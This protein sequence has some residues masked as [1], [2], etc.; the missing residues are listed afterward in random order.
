MTNKLETSLVIKANVDGVS[1]VNELAKSVDKVNQEL[2]GTKSPSASAKTAI[3]GL[4]K[5]MSETAINATTLKNTLNGLKG[6][7]AGLGVTV[8]A[9]ELLDMAEGFKSLEA[10][11]KLATGEGVNFVNAM[12]GLKAVANETNAGLDETATLFT[13]IDGAGK[14]LGLTQK[15][16]LE[17]TKSPRQAMT[18]RLPMPFIFGQ[19]CPTIYSILGR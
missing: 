3:D 8:G 1:K 5:E 6:M 16:S 19:P 15:E 13:K 14:A 4:G 17:V 12:D 2:V 7:L 11:V 18:H 9:K 10:K